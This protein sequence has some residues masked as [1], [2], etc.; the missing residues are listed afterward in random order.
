MTWRTLLLTTISRI[1]LFLKLFVSN[2]TGSLGGTAH[3]LN[4]RQKSK[5]RIMK[6]IF[7]LL[8]IFFTIGCID[9]QSNSSSG[10]DIIVRYPNGN[11]KKTG[12]LIDGKKDGIFFSFFRNEEIEGYINFVDDKKHGESVKYYPNGKQEYYAFYFR[13]EL[14]YMKKYDNSGNAERQ[15]G[16]TFVTILSEKNVCTDSSFFITVFPVRPA[17]T[18]YSYLIEELTDDKKDTLLHIE[19]L[20]KETYKTEYKTAE[21]GILQFNM[22]L[23]LIDTVYADTLTTQKITRINVTPCSD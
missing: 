5:L 23:S 16:V 19:N 14:V 2:L 3:S 17:Y 8:L 22:K 4:T 7:C 1:V 18:K 20:T 9:N 15:K 21:T 12:K 6:K 11:L 13:D 10:E